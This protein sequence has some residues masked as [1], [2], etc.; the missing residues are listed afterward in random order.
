M[1]WNVCC[2]G[3]AQLR[4]VPPKQLYKYVIALYQNWNLHSTSGVWLRPEL[5]KCSTSNQLSLGSR[6]YILL[7]VKVFVWY[8]LVC[9]IE[10]TIMDNNWFIYAKLQEY[11]FLAE[12][13]VSISSTRHE[14]TFQTM[15]MLIKSLKGINISS[16]VP[17]FDCIHHII[18]NQKD[19]YLDTAGLR[20]MV[21]II[22]EYTV[23][24]EAT[25]SEKDKITCTF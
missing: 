14:N 12:V 18:R 8:W 6:I 20:I 15:R 9:N 16:W 11:I 5:L 7:N 4:T 22:T 3:V 2:T 10:I 17:I 23:K 1:N 21:F 25:G 24:R 19:C 13:I